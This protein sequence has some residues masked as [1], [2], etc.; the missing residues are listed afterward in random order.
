MPLPTPDLTGGTSDLRPVALCPGCAAPLIGT[1]HWARFEFYCLDCGRH[2]EFLA[3]DQGEP[4]FELL[5]RMEAYQAEW[6]EHAA[7][8]LVTSHAWR[9]EQ[10][11]LCRVGG[12][13]H[14]Q[15]ATAAEWGDHQQ[16]V[17]WI[18]ARIRVAA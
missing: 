17:E 8:Q 16:A 5:E 14:E 18:A 4:T 3:P 13:Y 2:V 11:A 12:A 1:F 15:H 10:C 6:A 9:P 7:G